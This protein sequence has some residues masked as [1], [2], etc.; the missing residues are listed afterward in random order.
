MAVAEPEGGDP[1]CWLDHVCERCGRFL[2]RPED[3]DCEGDDAPP[4]VTSR[5]AG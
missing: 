1:A 5:P 4:P 2:E 3:H